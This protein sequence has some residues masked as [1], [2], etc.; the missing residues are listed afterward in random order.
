MV[1]HPPPEIVEKLVY[2]EIDE[3]WLVCSGEPVIGDVR[4]DTDIPYQDQNDAWFDCWTK[5]GKVRDLVATWPK[6]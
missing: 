4:Q 1:L 3:G 6:P 5:L 2:P